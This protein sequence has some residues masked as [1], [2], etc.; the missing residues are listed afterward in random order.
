MS[1]RGRGARYLRT[2]FDKEGRSGIV[3]FLLKILGKNQ[4][5][6]KSSVR[7]ESILN[8]PQEKGFWEEFEFQDFCLGGSLI[9]SNLQRL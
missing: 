9:T 7:G 6:P 1:D 4:D 8:V 5:F 2:P 3:S